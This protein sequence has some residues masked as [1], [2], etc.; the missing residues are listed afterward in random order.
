[1]TRTEKSWSH[2]RENQNNALLKIEKTPSQGG[3]LTALSL[4]RIRKDSKHARSPGV[5]F[6]LKSFTRETCHPPPPPALGHH[7]TS[8]P[9]KPR[10]EFMIRPTQ[11]F[12]SNCDP[13]SVLRFFLFLYQGPYTPILKFFPHPI[14]I[15]YPQKKLFLPLDFPRL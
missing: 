2:S 10:N 11:S 15:T 1:M 6:F 8:P 7:H 4:K 9:S 12:L 3:T 13:V 5:L 14:K